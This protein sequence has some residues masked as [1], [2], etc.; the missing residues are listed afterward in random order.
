MTAAIYQAQHLLCPL[1]KK[2]LTCAAESKSFLCE[3]NHTFDI[4][5]QGYVNLLPVQQKRSK[6]PGDSKEMVLARKH[7]LE[8]GYY[9]PLADALYQQTLKSMSHSNQPA[10]V[11]DAG[12]G[13]GYY[14]KQLHQRLHAQSHKINTYAFDISK[15]AITEA[16]KC[17]AEISWFVST[18]KDVPLAPRSVDVLISVFSPLQTAHFQQLL[19]PNGTLITL[20]AGSNH[21]QQLKELIYTDVSTY[22]P[23]KA[24]KQLQPN[25]RLEKRQA[26]QY[27]LSLTKP[28]HINA[29]LSMTPHF[30]KASPDTKARLNALEHLELDIDVQ[31][32][33]F[34]PLEIPHE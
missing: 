16:A 19:S 4:A 20:S 12:C 5:K 6:Q 18:I 23:D 9:Q 17:S 2:P 15:P 7:F 21:L 28:S 32:M 3:R 14:T 25:F 22:D 26:L 24:I 33:T 34:Q 31:L 1:C 10:L 13:E 30:W 8:L 11:L 29:L 27:T